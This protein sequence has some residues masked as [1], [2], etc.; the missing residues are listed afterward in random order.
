MNKKI[1]S[2]VV[3]VII[4]LIVAL[5]FKQKAV[6]PSLTETPVSSTSVEKKATALT[7]DSLKNVKVPASWEDGQMVELT[8]GRYETKT[9][10]LDKN[11]KPL[12][13][14][15]YYSAG[16]QPSTTTYAV[17]DFDGDGA[18]DIFAT[19]G[20]SSGGTGFFIDLLAYKNVN[21]VAEYAGKLFLG[22]RIKVNQISADKNT[23]TVDI[24]TQGPNEGLCCGTTRQVKKYTF[25]GTIFKEIE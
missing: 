7:F 11:G 19:L 3:I 17:S 25:D 5:S 18:N 20:S 24:I 1:L 9:Q 22:D 21:G 16:L 8:N 14:F 2:I 15:E 6:A 23:V 10:A 13:F 4:I 12:D